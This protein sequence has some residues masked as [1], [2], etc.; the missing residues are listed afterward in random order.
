[1][2]PHV[3]MGSRLFVLP[4]LRVFRLMATYGFTTQREVACLLSIS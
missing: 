3:V 4:G 1:V 2:F